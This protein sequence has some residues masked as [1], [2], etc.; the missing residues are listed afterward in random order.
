PREPPVVS[1]GRRKR[2]A[3]PLDGRKEA[4]RGLPDRGEKPR[5]IPEPP[6]DE[7]MKEKRRAG[8]D[9]RSREAEQ[10]GGEGAGDPVRHAAAPKAP[11]HA[12][13]QH[14]REKAGEQ[15]RH[16]MEEERAE[17]CGPG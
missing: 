16:E 6:A 4:P 12:A 11:R 15:R 13:Q 5:E 7:A 10:R 14:G 17:E 8:H 1:G 2:K 9:A 3:E